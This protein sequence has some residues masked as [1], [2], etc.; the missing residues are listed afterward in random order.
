MVIESSAYAL[1]RYRREFRRVFRL[2][3]LFSV[4]PDDGLAQRV[5][6]VLLGDGRQ[7][8]HVV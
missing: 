6:G 5:L 3:N 2:A 8:Q 7:V 1:P 4:R